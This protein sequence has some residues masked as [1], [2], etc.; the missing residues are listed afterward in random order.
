MVLPAVAVIVTV[1]VPAGVPGL[2]ITVGLLPPQETKAPHTTSTAT[3]KNAAS[4]RRAR[5]R[6][7]RPPNKTSPKKPAVVPKPAPSPVAGGAAVGA[8]VVMV[9]VVGPLVVT[10][11]GLNEQLVSEG[12]P[13]V[14]LKLTVPVK[15]LTAPTLMVYIADC[16]GLTEELTVGIVKLK[17][18]EETV[19]WADAWLAA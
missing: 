13:E 11:V 16:P 12:R 2:C 3:R 8:V 19:T 6:A 4:Q 10:V 18:P 9:S 5:F 14:Q 1:D 15:P 7:V 17:S